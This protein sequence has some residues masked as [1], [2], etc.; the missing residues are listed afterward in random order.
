MKLTVK[1][2]ATFKAYLPGDI[3]GHTCAIEFDAN[4]TVEEVLNQ[5]RIPE[6]DHKVVLVNGTMTNADQ[7]LREGDVISVF[8]P[9][10]GG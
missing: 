4:P 8:P 7:V 9:I 5:L 3:S 1:L 2:F 6:G 10:A